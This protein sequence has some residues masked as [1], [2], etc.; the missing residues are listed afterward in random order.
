NAHLIAHIC[1]RLDGMPLAIELA[2]ARVNSLS[3]EQI[4]T[5][6]DDRFG[7]L[8]GGSRT[9][10]PRQ[11]TLRATMDW[12]YNLLTAEERSL[13]QRLAVFAGGW[14]LEAVEAVGAADD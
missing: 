8:T 11:Q 2:T 10:L 7:L 5:R 6:L 13:F 3:L 12:S 1:R 4:A 14:S 9:A